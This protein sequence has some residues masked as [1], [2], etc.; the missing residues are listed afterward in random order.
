MQPT[1]AAVLLDLENILHNDPGP[2]RWPWLQ[3]PA[4]SEILNRCLLTA[5]TLLRTTPDHI[6][7]V[8]CP[9][10]MRRVAFLPPLHA[11]PC[12]AVA[13]QPNSADQRLLDDATHLA[14]AGFTRFVIASGDHIFTDFAAHH[15][16]YVLARPGTLSH[17]LRQAAAHTALIATR[18]RLLHTKRPSTRHVP[19]NTAAAT[20]TEPPRHQRAHIGEHA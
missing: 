20:P 11:L 6:L 10:L 15:E 3:G 12:R 18:N 8:S 13:S 19:E 7:A 16:T 5:N 9:A 14:A 4:A 1:R 17:R 2:G